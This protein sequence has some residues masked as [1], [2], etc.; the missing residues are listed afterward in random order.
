MAQLPILGVRGP[1]QR[2]DGWARRSRKER[3]WASHM[4][5]VVLVHTSRG[6]GIPDDLQHRRRNHCMGKANE[7]R[8]HKSP[9]RLRQKSKERRLGPS[10]RLAS[11]GEPPQGKLSM[12]PHRRKEAHRDD[13]NRKLTTPASW[14]HGELER[15]GLH[16]ANLR[17]HGVRLNGVDG[18][19]EN[20]NWLPTSYYRPGAS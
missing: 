10:T 9:V 17:G 19:N 11:H 4:R 15:D 13:S 14:V 8:R 2:C 3:Q 1:H 5:E 16:M 6:E 7:S 18:D 12:L 20:L